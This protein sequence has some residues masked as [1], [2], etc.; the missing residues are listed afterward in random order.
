MNQPDVPFAQ[1]PAARVDLAEVLGPPMTDL[2]ARASL[3]ADP[4][5]YLA[6]VGVSI[7]RWLTVTVI[8]QEAPSLTIALAPL[9]D[10]SAIAE[11]FLDSANGGGP[12]FP[13]WL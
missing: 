1:R 8:E 3:L 6:A 11:I 9:I 12:R 10:E 7:P 5:A 4:G 13:P 2:V